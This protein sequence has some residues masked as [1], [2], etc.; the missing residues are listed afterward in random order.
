MRSYLI[1][2]EL[3]NAFTVCN[4]LIEEFI[5]NKIND[6]PADELLSDNVLTLISD[7]VNTILVFCCKQMKLQELTTL[8]PTHNAIKDTR[9]D[10][11]N[12][13][14]TFLFSI[15]EVR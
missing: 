2:G 1:A 9:Q 13:H 4:L 15:L 6:S 10:V 8:P 11:V 3:D 7:I 12:L 5:S 14:L